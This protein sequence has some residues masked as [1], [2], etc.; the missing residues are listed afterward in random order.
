MQFVFKAVDGAGF[1]QQGTL[2]AASE[3]EALQ[4]LFERGYTPL[5]LREEKRLEHTASGAT[6]S[7]IKHVDVIALIREMA[8]LLASGVG[9]SEAFS[10]LLEASSHPRLKVT[11]G[12]LSAAV[13]G[14]EGFAAALKKSNLKLPEY[15]HALAKAGEATGDLAGA[16]TRSAEQLEFEERM[17]GEAREALTYPI[18]LILTG[19]GAIIFIFSFVVPRFAG[20][21]SGRNVDLPLLSEW[22]LT[23]GVFVNAHWLQIIIGL[24]IAGAGVSVLLRD[25]RFRVAAI[26]ALGRLPLLSSWI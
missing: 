5:D 14:G 18:I 16:L 2:V 4:Q 17:R 20:I 1:A 11:L 24:A 10:T 23:T 8:T 21:L 6:Q 3:T 22:V 19:I 15:V 13:H 9:L 25:E 7:A 26:V 12:E